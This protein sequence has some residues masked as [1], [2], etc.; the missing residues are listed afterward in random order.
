MAGAGGALN[1]GALANMSVDGSYDG[2]APATVGSEASYSPTSIATFEFGFF[3]P[4]ATYT[5]QTDSEGQGPFPGVTGDLTGSALT[6]DLSSWTAW[7]NGTD[8]NQGGAANSAVTTTTTGAGAF[9]AT[10][11]ATVVGGAF[12]GQV[13]SWT[14]TGVATPV[15]VPAAAWLFGSGLIGLVGVARRRR[16]AA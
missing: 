1:P 2:S 8:F 5:Q 16:A 13:G 15:P 4:V 6:L 3:G 14:L 11:S 9:S 10:W 12:D 7:W